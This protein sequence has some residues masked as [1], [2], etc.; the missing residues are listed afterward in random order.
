[1]RE[2]DLKRCPCT[3]VRLLKFIQ[4]FVEF[5]RER[6]LS[7]IISISAEYYNF[8][9]VTFYWPNHTPIKMFIRKSV[10]SSRTI[11]EISIDSGT[12][13]QFV[14]SRAEYVFYT[15]QTYECL[16]RRPIFNNYSEFSTLLSSFENVSGSMESAW[17]L[18]C[19][20]FRRYI[21]YLRIQ[22][23]IHKIPLKNSRIRSSPEK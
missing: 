10:F 1:M 11:N 16:C 2:V 8:L 13:K 22:L 17:N 20:E 9:K 7:F 21:S 12:K 23:K 5:H 19:K 6:Y 18:N 4:N 15:T 14:S 3:E